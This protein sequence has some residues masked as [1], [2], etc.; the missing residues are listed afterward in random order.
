[1]KLCFVKQTNK[2][3]SLMIPVRNWSGRQS[4]AHNM[5][6]LQVQRCTKFHINIVEGI[7]FSFLL[8]NFFLL[9]LLLLWSLE[10]EI[11]KIYNIITSVQKI[12]NKL[13]IQNKNLVPLLWDWLTPLPPFWALQLSFSS[14]S[15]LSVNVGGGKGRKKGSIFNKVDFLLTRMLSQA[16]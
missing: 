4:C 2:K 10:E 9:F 16:P 11:V 14:F 13:S 1:M 6:H 5:T 8:F 7:L 15:L 3:P 12:S